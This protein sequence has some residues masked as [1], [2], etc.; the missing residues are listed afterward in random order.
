VTSCFEN[1]NNNEEIDNRMDELVDDE[2]DKYKNYNSYDSGEGT[3]ERSS[4][5]SLG[6]KRN[7]EGNER[8]NSHIPTKGRCFWQ[9]ANYDLVD[10]NVGVFVASG[11]VIACNPWE[12]IY[13]EAYLDF[14][15]V[16]PSTT[17][18]DSFA[19]SDFNQFEACTH[20]ETSNVQSTILEEIKGGATSFLVSISKQHNRMVR[21]V[22][23]F[24]SLKPSKLMFIPTKQSYN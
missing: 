14:V 4:S 3:M 13:R 2:S 17:L 10:S 7:E 6:E 18:E 9:S 11:H 12:G 1:F 5:D 20:G 19:T 15:Y 16:L 23:S 8:K 22:R 24:F 21:H